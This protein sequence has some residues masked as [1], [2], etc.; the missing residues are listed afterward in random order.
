M[1]R[2]QND[3][4]QPSLPTIDVIRRP[5][6]SGTTAPTFPSD[7]PGSLPTSGSTKRVGVLGLPPADEILRRRREAEREREIRRDSGRM[8]APG[9][10]PPDGRGRLPDGTTEPRVRRDD[11]ISVLLD[12]LYTTADSYLSNLA[13]K[14]GG[15]LL[16]ADVLSSLPDAFAKIAAELRTQYLI[17]Y[18]PIKKDRD[19]KYRRIKVTSK[20]KGVLIRSRPGYLASSSR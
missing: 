17:G 5:P 9:D 6:A 13:D 11:S 15:K 3:Q 8:P 1:A 18:Y 7:D 4:I 2:E 14:S 12:V 19:D 10:I 16:R 20:R